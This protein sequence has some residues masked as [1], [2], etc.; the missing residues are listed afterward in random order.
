MNKRSNKIFLWL[1]II[2]AF[3]ILVVTIIRAFNQFNFLDITNKDEKKEQV[4]SKA[5]NTA[6][7]YVY[8][9]DKSVIEQTLLSKQKQKDELNINKFESRNTS[10]IYITGISYI[11]IFNK[12]LNYPIS[13]NVINSMLDEKFKKDKNIDDETLKEFA[14]E[15]TFIPYGICEIFQESNL[16]KYLFYGYRVNEIK[17][18][19]E[20]YGY[21]ITLNH[22]ASAF[23][24]A[25]YTF[26]ELK[27]VISKEDSYTNNLLSLNEYNRI[28]IVDDTPEK[29]CN[30]IF[31]LFKYNVIY[32]YELAFDELEA[33]YSKKFGSSKAF[34]TYV[35]S[36][37]SKLES[38]QIESIT[39]K[40]ENEIITYRCIDQNKNSFYII[41]NEKD[42]FD[43]KIQFSNII[44]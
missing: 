20:N 24:I 25:P 14:G 21:I 42:F 6:S 3:V 12:N 37:Q 33:E 8:L 23:S 26:N 19:A 40:K 16:N 31:R 18:T 9:K 29:D 39:Y 7:E 11:N 28:N 38:I 5:Q 41:T 4:I 32:N 34:F 22:S 44:F 15:Y 30:E 10:N 36:N 13:T 17:N 1:I 2:T 27:D 35:E 43:F